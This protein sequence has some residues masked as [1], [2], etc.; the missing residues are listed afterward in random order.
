MTLQIYREVMMLK[1]LATRRNGENKG[2][3][4]VEEKENNR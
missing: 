2:R 1:Q 3:K 4:K